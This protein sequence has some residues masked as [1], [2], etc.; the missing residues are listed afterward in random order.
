[1]AFASHTNDRRHIGFDPI[2]LG[3]F[4]EADEGHTFEFGD[5]WSAPSCDFCSNPWASIDEFPHVIFTIEGKRYARVL[6]TV[7]YIVVDEDELGQPVIEK[8]ETRGRRA[9]DLP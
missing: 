3:H 7:A 1:M 6:K 2:I 5:R 9:Y 4:R 8:W